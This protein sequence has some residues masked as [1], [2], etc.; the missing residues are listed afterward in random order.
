MAEVV[1]V[2]LYGYTPIWALL[3][4]LVLGMGMWATSAVASLRARVDTLEA[5][6]RSQ[7]EANVAQRRYNESVHEK[8]VDLLM[9][10][11][12]MERTDGS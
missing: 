10:I 9:R 1:W 8:C 6:L 5:A 7:V 3:L 12:K 2:P 4:C 11:K